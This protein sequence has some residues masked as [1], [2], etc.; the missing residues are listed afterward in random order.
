M[1][2]RG[3]N[4]KG[5]MVYG[6]PAYGFGMEQ[7]AGIETPDGD[8]QEIRP[9]TFGE[10]TEYP[11][12][13]GTG[14]YTGDVTRLILRGDGASLYDVARMVIDR[15]MKPQKGFTSAG[16]S[17][18]RL[19]TYVFIRIETGTVLL[20]G[21]DATGRCDTEKMEIVGNIHQNPELLV[22]GGG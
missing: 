14:I 6:L 13:N 5:E 12:I 11:D 9:E 22:R 4:D 21:V 18:V 1:R 16:K 17:V 8:F 7:I 3:L 2:C 10:Y 20:P 15:E 19:N